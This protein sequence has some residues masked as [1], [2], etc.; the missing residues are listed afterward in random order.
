MSQVI[1]TAVLPVAGFGTRFLPVTK[2]VPKEMLPLLDRPC[3]EYAVVEAV[4]AGIERVVMVTTH[5][6]EALPDYFDVN[7]ELERHLADQGKLELLT[8]VRQLND[9][10]DV[11]TVRQRDT[12][13]LGHAVLS[14]RAAVG[15]EPFAVLLADDVIDADRPVLGQL[16]AAWEPTRAAVALMDVPRDQTRHYGVCA[17][18]WL[19]PGRMD[20]QRMVEKPDPQDAPSTLAI[21]GRYLLPPDIFDVLE[22]TP[23]GAANEYQ[24]TDALAALA[25]QGR[26]TGVVFEGRRFDAG[27]VLGWLEANLH[28][29]LQRPD[30]ADDVRAMLKRL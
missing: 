24:L 17:G 18:P 30:L 8:M 27:G 10:V 25:S 6:K 2:A 13:G 5:G 4:A 19:A 9:L 15:D 16:M 11:V 14:A 7:P 12:R 29:A 23:R 3:I 28:F 22:A 26:V 1:H 21:V 20:V